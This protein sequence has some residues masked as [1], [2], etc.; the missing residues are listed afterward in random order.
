MVDAGGRI[1][2]R[3]GLGLATTVL[4]AAAALVGRVHPAL[5]ALAPASGALASV[6][7]LAGFPE[8]LP[9]EYGACLLAA[10]AGLVA[11]AAPRA[12]RPRRSAARS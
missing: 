6:A 1:V 10:L 9:V 11:T 4:A 8:M 2:A 5:A 3:A 7:L 12:A